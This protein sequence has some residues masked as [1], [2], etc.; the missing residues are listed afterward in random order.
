MFL[1]YSRRE[2]KFN[3]NSR[4]RVS[5]EFRLWEAVQRWLMASS[6]PERRGNTASPLLASIIPFIKFVSTTF[7]SATNN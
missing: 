4:I 2:E 3:L 1:F 7:Y 5:D 6:H